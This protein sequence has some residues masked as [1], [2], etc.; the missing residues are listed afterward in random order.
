MVC[1]RLRQTARTTPNLHRRTHPSS[2]PAGGVA[3]QDH[4]TVGSMSI[5]PYSLQSAED[6]QSNDGHHRAQSNG[7][8]DSQEPLPPRDS[9]GKTSQDPNRPTS[10]EYLPQRVAAR[11]DRLEHVRGPSSGSPA[12]L[13]AAE[14]QQSA[15]APPS[16]PNEH[17]RVQSND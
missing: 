10:Y 12:A 3:V 9:N 13:Y 14:Q 5:L 8:P 16:P 15:P 1:L 2:T 17:R 11:D 6:L 7:H 4:P